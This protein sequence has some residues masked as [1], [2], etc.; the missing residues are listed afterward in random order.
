MGPNSAWRTANTTI[1]LDRIMAGNLLRSARV[2]AGPVG[3]HYR[4]SASASNN[5]STYDLPFLERSGK[6]KP[7][8]AVDGKAKQTATAPAGQTE[9]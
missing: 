9:L 4:S 2:T 5:A 1:R 6:Q 3:L 8:D 7:L